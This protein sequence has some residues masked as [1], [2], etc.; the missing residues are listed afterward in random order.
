M[1]V[2]VKYLRPIAVQCG[3]K[4]GSQGA[5]ALD[6]I[7]AIDE[8]INLWPGSEASIPTGI[9]LHMADPNVCAVILPRSGLGAKNGI[10]L[11]N[12]VGL[13]D[14]DYQGEVIV[15]AW[16]RRSVGSEMRN[17]PRFTINPGDRIAQMMF[18]PVLHPKLVRV[19]EFSASTDR[20]AGGFG[21]TGVA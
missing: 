15:A 10:V 20:G 6:L 11:G 16:Y 17:N 7:A 14:S 13:I 5:A 9:A 3:I 4:Y 19:E 12:L 18:L 1:N 2:E 21:S 8:P